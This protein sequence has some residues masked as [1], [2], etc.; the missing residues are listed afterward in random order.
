M[1]EETLFADSPDVAARVALGVVED[2]E[3]DAG[4]AEDAGKSL[5]HALVARVERC[6][7]ADEPQNLRRLLANVLYVEL[8]LSRP[9]RAPSACLSEGVAGLIDR[10]QG[11]LERRVHLAAFDQPSAHLVDDRDV[12][13]PN[14]ADLDAG[15]ALHARPERLR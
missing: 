12:L 5:R 2:P 11:L 4:V 7:V 15:H 3:V 8:E 1:V 13:D 14:R 9:A 10:L 6:V